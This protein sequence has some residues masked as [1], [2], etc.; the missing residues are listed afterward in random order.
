MSRPPAE[1]WWTINGQ[2]ILDALTAA[3]EG[4]S[5]DLV[6][7]ELHANSDGGTDHGDLC[8]EHAEQAHDLALL[9]A[10]HHRID[11]PGGKCTCGHE[12]PLGEL[13][14]RHIA[15]EII[16]AGWTQ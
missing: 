3:H 14:S 6:Y 9:I 1:Q 15:D 4:T 2:A 11:A 7:L 16:A 8:D 5:P 13:C 10:N 12:T